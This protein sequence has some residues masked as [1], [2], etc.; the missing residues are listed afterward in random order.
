MR[1]SGWSSLAI[2]VCSALALTFAASARAHVVATPGFLPAGDSGTLNLMA[3][4][5]RD[6]PMTGFAV[7]VPSEFLIVHAHPASGWEATVEG[8]TASWTGG[9]LA[10]R[11]EATFALEL[12]APTEPGPAV[13]EASQLYSGGDVVRWP[14]ALTVVPAAETPSQNLGWMVV[15]GLL[16]LVA[17]TG[18]GAAIV[19]RARSLQEK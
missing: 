3:P 6:E 11:S 14:V 12:E 7:M 9:S 13:L 17:L 16:V 2:S 1:C 18:I 8:A 19:R 4:N 5:E 10:S 15:T